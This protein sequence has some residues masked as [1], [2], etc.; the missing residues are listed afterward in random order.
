MT[1]STWLLLWAVF[2]LVFCL[3]WPR[4]RRKQAA[5]TT[6]IDQL[7]R[8]QQA[9]EARM[10]AREV[11]GAKRLILD[12]VRRETIEAVAQHYEGKKNEMR[13]YQFA[14]DIRKNIEELAAFAGCDSN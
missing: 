6:V 8:Q 3:V 9:E 2:V 11:K 4:L 7:D 5:D 13:G 12:M 14:A 10:E 1:L